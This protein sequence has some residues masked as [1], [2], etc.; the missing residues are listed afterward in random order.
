M[1]VFLNGAQNVSVGLETDPRTDVTINENLETDVFVSSDEKIGVDVEQEEKVDIV[2]SD[3]VVFVSTDETYKG[4]YV[5]TPKFEDKILNT[6][7][8]SMQED[9]KINAIPVERVANTSGGN[10]VI[11]GS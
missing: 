8:K 5:I 1:Q 11:I 3:K 10:T 6:K 7:N 9:V 2:F 4:E